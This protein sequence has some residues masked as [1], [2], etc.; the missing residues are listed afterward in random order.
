[1]EVVGVFFGWIDQLVAKEEIYLTMLVL[2]ATTNW[3]GCP[4]MLALLLI[5]VSESL[6]SLLLVQC[7]IMACG[8]LCVGR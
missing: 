8:S 6:L 7:S 1:M 2:D 5:Y 4:W 3:L